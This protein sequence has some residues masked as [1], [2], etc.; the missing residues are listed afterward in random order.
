MA[1]VGQKAQSPV[2]AQQAAPLKSAAATEFAGQETCVLCHADIAKKFSSNPHSALALLHGGK[3]V[4]CEGCHGPGAA[5]VA[6]GGDPTKILQLSKMSA[7]QI[8]ATC[9]GCHASA[10]PNFER[11]D[12]FKG[13]VSCTSCHSIHGYVPGA[14]ISLAPIAA[15]NPNLHRSPRSV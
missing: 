1:S 12:H 11:S 9:L 8:D 4:T 13:G 14:S 6:S 5:H 15:G 2:V 3:G 7:K 10:H